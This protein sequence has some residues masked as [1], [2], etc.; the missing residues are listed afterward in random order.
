VIDEKIFQACYVEWRGQQ[1]SRQIEDPFRFAYEAT[2]REL[3]RRKGWPAI[4]AT[5]AFFV[6]LAADVLV[7]WS[8]IEIDALPGHWVGSLPA[9]VVGVAVYAVLVVLS[10]TWSQRLDYHV[11]MAIESN[12][13]KRRSTEGARDMMQ[14][15]ISSFS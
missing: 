10:R 2:E 13:M 15:A 12:E 11:G 8:S 1:L 7:R 9:L 14:R 5:T 3:G 6:G 4:H